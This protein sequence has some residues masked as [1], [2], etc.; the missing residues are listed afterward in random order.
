MAA[1]SIII[2]GGKWLEISIAADPLYQH[3]LPTAEKKFWR[4]VS[5]GEPL[6]CSGSNHRGR[7]SRRLRIVDMGASNYWGGI[8]G[9]VPLD[10][11][12]FLV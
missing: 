10:P 4:C 3:L 9:G 1:L 11:V 7:G 8:R 5:F 12:S 6:A 2:G